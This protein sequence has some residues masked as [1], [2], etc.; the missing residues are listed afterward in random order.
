ML[1]MHCVFLFSFPFENKITNAATKI[2]SFRLQKCDAC[3]CYGMLYSKW[4]AFKN[5]N[6]RRKVHH[7][8]TQVKEMRSINS[9]AVPFYRVDILRLHV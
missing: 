5:N 8:Y 6:H 2:N 7:F 9:T 3:T 4:N 1:Y